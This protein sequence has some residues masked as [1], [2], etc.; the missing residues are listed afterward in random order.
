MDLLTAEENENWT[1]LL[2]A[3]VAAFILAGAVGFALDT[4]DQTQERRRRVARSGRVKPDEPDIRQVRWKMTA[5][6]SQV[7]GKS[8]HKQKKAVARVTPRV[9][10]VVRDFY[11][12]LTV[13]RQRLK[14]VSRRLMA[15][16]ARRALKGQPLVPFGM[17]RVKTMKRV[18]RIAIDPRTHRTAAAQIALTFKADRGKKR[19]KFTHKGT[20]W[21]DRG[22]ER[23]RIIAFDLQQRKIT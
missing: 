21:I 3:I 17:H 16:P 13:S 22:K 8:T 10:G 12:A 18:A 20:L 5:W 4:D 11:D 2:A 23:W 19:L 6:A 7:P 1:A 9:K 15:P 14:G